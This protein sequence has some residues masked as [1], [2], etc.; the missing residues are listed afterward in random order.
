MIKSYSRWRTEVIRW[1]GSGEGLVGGEYRADELMWE[2]PGA[3]RTRNSQVQCAWHRG[4]MV[5]G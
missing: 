1:Q 3:D 5:G 2:D 4:I